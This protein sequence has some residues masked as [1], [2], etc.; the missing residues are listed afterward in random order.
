M[1]ALFSVEVRDA[2]ADAFTALLNG[3]SV[4][5]YEGVTLIGTVTLDTPAFTASSVGVCIATGLP[6]AYTPAATPT[7][8]IDQAKLCTSGGAVRVSGLTVSAPNGGGQ[9]IVDLVK[10]TINIAAQLIGLTYIEPAS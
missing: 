5:L 7:V 8:A 10:P 1:S 9:V 6:I 2:K 4:K 3:G